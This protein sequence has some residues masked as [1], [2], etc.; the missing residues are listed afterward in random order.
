MALISVPLSVLVATVIARRSQ[1][2]F[3]DQW[4]ETGHL[5]G[6]IEEVGVSDEGVPAWGKDCEF[7]THGSM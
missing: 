4:R 3:V 6:H 5:N 7:D 2:L 1:P